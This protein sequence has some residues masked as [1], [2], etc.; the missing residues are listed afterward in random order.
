MA[1]RNPVAPALPL[2]LNAPGGSG[3]APGNNPV[4]AHVQVSRLAER[5]RSP[6]AP[7]LNSDQQLP[8]GLDSQAPPPPDSEQLTY[9]RYLNMHLD[10][11]GLRRLLSTHGP[12]CFSCGGKGHVELEC[13]NAEAQ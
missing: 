11:A 13:P 12:H 10:L 5:N 6:P 8:S 4:L 2:H 9:V 3:H 1:V 7:A